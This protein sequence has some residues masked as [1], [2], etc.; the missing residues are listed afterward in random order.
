MILAGDSGCM[1]Q[2]GYKSTI[3]VTMDV[4]ITMAKTAHRDAPI[5][6]RFGTY[7]EDDIYE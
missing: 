4:M 2:L 6:F 5:L 7:H 1:V 3:P